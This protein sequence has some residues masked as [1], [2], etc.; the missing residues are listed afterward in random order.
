MFLDTLRH[1]HELFAAMQPHVLADINCRVNVAVSALKDTVPLGV[2]KALR[3]DLVYAVARHHHFCAA[4]L[5]VDIL[6]DL[7]ASDYR[8]TRNIAESLAQGATDLPTLDGDSA[9]LS[10][11]PPTNAEFLRSVFVASAAAKSEQALV[12]DLGLGTA[13]LMRIRETVETT[14][15]GARTERNVVRFLPEIDAQITDI[16]VELANEAKAVPW[17]VQIHR[18]RYHLIG[19]T[20]PLSVWLK[21]HGTKAVFDLLL[22][23]GGRGAASARQIATKLKKL[24]VPDG[25]LTD[26]PQTLLQ[27]LSDLDLVYA[28]NDTEAIDRRRWQLTPF[29]QELTA[30]AFARNL[31]NKARAPLKELQGL[32]AAYQ[33]AVIRAAEVTREALE[34]AAVTSR[35]LAPQALKALFERLDSEF[36]VDVATATAIVTLNKESSPWLRKVAESYSSRHLIVGLESTPLARSQDAP[37]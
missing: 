7:L 5:F 8:L 26:D 28:S 33:V 1:R 29:A 16:L 21:V 9:L 3:T 4:P 20:P 2:L 22:A 18:L 24:G 32:S 13:L 31:I 19:A 11:V 15:S 37:A 35:P 14:V 23:I 17:I 6:A 27:A 36:G 30:D 10:A 12:I 25:A 34:V